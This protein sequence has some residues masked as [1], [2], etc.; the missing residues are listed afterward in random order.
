[1]L[2]KSKGNK[3]EF[4][5]FKRR[6]IAM[7]S[8]IPNFEYSFPDSWL[9]QWENDQLSRWEDENRCDIDKEDEKN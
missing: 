9:I 5:T 4:K 2:K 7:F 6:G 3:R 1:M 8:S